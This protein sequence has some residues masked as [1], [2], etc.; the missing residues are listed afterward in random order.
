[1]ASETTLDLDAKH[2]SDNSQNQYKNAWD[3]LNAMEIGPEFSILDVGCGHGQIIS[4]LSRKAPFGRSI[5]IDASKNMIEYARDSY[6]SSKFPNL[7][8]YHKKAEELDF[9]EN[10]FDLILCTNALLWVRQ[11]SLALDLMS[12]F[13]KPGG[14]L[15][16]FTYPKETAYA[17]LFETV[18]DKY[19]P[20]Y[21]KSSALS[22][23]L[24][25]NQ[26]KNIL[27][28]N[29]LYIEKFKID[30]VF[31]T[32]DNS[33]E[34][35]NY[36]RGWLVCFTPIPD[37]LHEEFLDK[38]VIEAPQFYADPSLN[39]IKIAHQSLSIQAIKPN[40]TTSTKKS[41]KV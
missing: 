32:Y 39:E 27:K 29:N 26:H 38:L 13:L 37:E 19:Y 2:Y 3:M 10:R 5:G 14:R 21:K 36:V 40:Q 6:S 30:N 17:R 20:S 4:E 16:L 15:I 41:R 28:R 11:P 31:F 25:T 33:E 24:S 35:K 8:F 34:F 1:M 23:M 18:L 22:T 12:K 9:S 7:K